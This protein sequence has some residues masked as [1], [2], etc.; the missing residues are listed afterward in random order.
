MN[1]ILITGATSLIGHFLLPRLA[2]QGLPVI[3]ISRQPPNPVGACLASDF[4]LNNRQQDWLLQDITQPFRLPTPCSTLLHLAPI[5]HLPKLLESLGSQ[6]PKRII[7]ISST[8]R[9]SKQNSSSHA[10]R[11]TARKLAEAEDHLTRFG[12]QHHIE[13]TIFRPT[14]IYGAG[15]DKNITTIA[16]FIQRFGFFPV[17]GKAQGL[18]QPLHADDIALACLTSL[19]NPTTFHHAYNLSGGETLTYREM[20]ERIFRSLGKPARILSIPPSVFHTSIH[21]ARFLP[22]FQ[23]LSPEMADRMN[24]DLVFPADHAHQDF[25]FV[26][27]SLQP[28]TLTNSLIKN[29][30]I[31]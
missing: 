15:L 1:P 11:E 29:K 27:R 8:S 3:A 12:Q 24:T 2:E 19:N 17:I 4:P 6:A 30:P 23:H 20:V 13:W 28:I 10:E 21:L 5:W 22:R 7:A 18:R 14:L 31:V 16:R 25:G 9:F 26:A